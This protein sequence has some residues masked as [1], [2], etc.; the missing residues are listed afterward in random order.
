MKHM[1]FYRPF[2]LVTVF[3][4]SSCSILNAQQLSFDSDM[5]NEANS[6]RGLGQFNLDVLSNHN[7]LIQWVQDYNESS[8]LLTKVYFLSNFIFP[9]HIGSL[10]NL[11]FHEFGHGSRAIATGHNASYRIAYSFTNNQF[12]PDLMGYYDLFFA[13]LLNPTIAGAQTRY[14][15]SKFS[16]LTEKNS[17]Y[18]ALISSNGVN[19]ETY[20]SALISDQNHDREQ[21][22]IFDYFTY[23]SAKLAVYK[24]AVAEELGVFGDTGSDLTAVQQFYNTQYNVTISH[25]DFKRYNLFSYLLSAQTWFYLMAMTDYLFDDKLYFNQLNYYGFRLPEVDFYLNMQGP[26]YQIRSEYRLNESLSIPFAFEYVFL[27]DRQTETTIGFV[28]SWSSFTTK[29]MLRFGTHM[30]RTFE[31]MYRFQ[32]KWQ[33]NVGY[34]SY[35]ARNLFGA[36]H[37]P[38]FSD[39]SLKSD[40]FF[41]GTTVLF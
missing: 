38:S 13:I 10:L 9:Y 4:I 28:R 32:P 18:D 20:F 6:S 2:F 19:M 30:T 16:H 17:F 5:V 36:R 7:A 12:G 33:F 8:K 15:G 35:S 37:M 3:I 24:Y 14:T 40:A 1:V 21:G 26:S 22:F 31:L 11:S 27:G 39:S 34:N 25:A 23:S 29:S 41:I